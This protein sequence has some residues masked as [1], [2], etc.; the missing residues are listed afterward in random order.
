MSETLRA[1]GQLKEAGVPLFWLSAY[2]GEGDVGAWL[3]EQQD[4]FWGHGARFIPVHR[5][6][7]TVQYLTRV[8]VCMTRTGHTHIQLLAR[9]HA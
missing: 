1:A 6:A 9:S 3:P 4:E 5:M 8:G 7:E 2:M